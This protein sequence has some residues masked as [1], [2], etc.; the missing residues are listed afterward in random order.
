MSAI[1]P[2]TIRPF[3][4]RIGC[5]AAVDRQD[6]ESM[7]ESYWPALI[8]VVFVLGWVISKLRYYMHKSE[9]QWRDVDKSKLR[10]WDDEGD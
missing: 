2:S 5:F 7:L 4:D 8:I 6:H 3:L 10:T 1:I 9:Q